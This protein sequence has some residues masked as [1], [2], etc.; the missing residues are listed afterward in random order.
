MIDKKPLRNPKD[1][2]NVSVLR[3]DHELIKQHLD[4]KKTGEDIGKFYNTAAIEKMQK[5]KKTKQ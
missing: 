5:E 2:I 3:C 1:Y 4:E